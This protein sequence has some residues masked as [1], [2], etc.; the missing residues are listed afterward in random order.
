MVAGQRGYMREERFQR[1]MDRDIEMASLFEGESEMAD[2]VQ[3]AMQ[4]ELQQA[5]EQHEQDTYYENLALEEEEE[6]AQEL[7]MMEVY[8]ALLLAEDR[9]LQPSETSNGASSSAARLP[10][11]FPTERP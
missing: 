6:Q 4:D 8:P 5:V 11:V 3:L 9:R 2:F 1:Q 10:S 7:F